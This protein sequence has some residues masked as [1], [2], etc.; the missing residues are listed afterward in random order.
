MD[1]QTLCTEDFYARVSGRRGCGER[2]V[3]EELRREF[4]RSEGGTYLDHAA[5]TLF[6]ESAVR[7]YCED[8]STNLYGNPHSHSPSSRLTHDSVERVRL[9]ILQ[10]FDADPEQYSVVFTS[11]C[12]SALRLVAESFPWRRGSVFSY[13]TDSHTSVVGMR[14]LASALGAV[15]LPV[16]PDDLR[17]GA[18]EDDSC[19][20]PH[21]FSFPAQSNFSGRKYPLSCVTGIRARRLYPACAYRGQWRVLLDAASFVCTS[22]LSLR[23]CRADFVPV[24]FYKMLGFPTG[25][26]ALLVRSDAAAALHKRYFGGGTAAAY[27]S[28][29]DYYVEAR[30]TTDRLEDGTISFLDVIALNHSFDAL[31]KLTGGMRSVQEHT[32]ALA[33]YTYLVLSSLRHGSGRSLAQVYAHGHFESASSQGPILTFNLLDAQGG[34][35][36]YSQVDRMASLYNIHLRTGCFCNTG[37]CQAFLGISSEQ[38]KSNLQAGHVCGDAVDLV[39]GRPTGAVRVSF[40]YMS[41]FDDCQNLLKFVVECFCS[42]AVSVDGGRIQAALRHATSPSTSTD[43]STDT[44]TS[45]RGPSTDEDRDELQRESQSHRDEG[46]ELQRESQSHRDK[47]EEPQS[48]RGGAYTLSKIYIYPVKSCGAFEV[49]RWP[50]GPRGLLYDRGWMVVNGNGVC[51]SQKREA[52]LC[53]IKPR[54]ELSNN[55]LQL[56]APEME[57]VSVPLETEAQSQICLSKVCGDRVETLDCG[58]G[59]ADW[60]SR[61]L[62]QTS[63]LIRLSPDFTRG[64]RK[65]T[66]RAAA[67]EVSASLSLVNEAQYLMINVSSVERIQR[68]VQRREQA[69]SEGSSVLDVQNIISRFRANLVLSGGGGA[70]EEDEWTHV[71]IGDARFTVSGPCGRCHMVGIDQ[72]SGARTREPLLSLSE[73]RGQRKVTFGVYLSHRLPENSRTPVFLCRGSSVRPVSLPRPNALPAPP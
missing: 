45:P 56:L 10:F 36:G 26:G 2:R 24:S 54:V 13:L 73:L 1:F 59:V 28:G 65:R 72:E 18:D 44:S 51:L 64:A 20:T 66:G 31:H 4:R 30:S 25:L 67:S 41:T 11:G 48:Q 69:L 60:L 57:S 14:G 16:A 39:E 8:V 7:N 22:P 43:T 32:F 55:R 52:R 27:L 19:Q 3:T 40:G 5:A 17:D 34:F 49:E 47:G 35:I 12:T 58:D 29:E 50:L 71:S 9:R 23:Q 63:R 42:G 38:M 21:L 6:P 15:T 37:A 46:E 68:L 62:G 33:R 70:F 53:L 61:F